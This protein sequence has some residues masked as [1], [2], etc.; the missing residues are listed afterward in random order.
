MNTDNHDPDR[1]REDGRRHSGGDGADLPALR[2]DFLPARGLDGAEGELGWTDD[3]GVDWE[4]LLYALRR[5]KWWIVAATVLGV[6]VGVFLA[7]QV[8]PVYETRATLWLEQGDDRR[9][10]IQAENVFQGQG[11]SDLFQSFAVLEPVVESRNLHVTTPEGDPVSSPLF[12]GFEQSE[13]LVPGLYQLR[14]DASGRLE[15]SREGEGV[16]DVALP[17]DSLGEGVGFRWVPDAG[18]LGSG[19]ALRFRVTPPPQAALDLRSKLTVLYNPQAGSLITT[20]LEGHDPK[21]TATIH[22]AVVSSFLEVAADLKS[23]KLREVV[24]ILERQT[25]IAE[26]RLRESE[27]RLENF[28]V[29]T[30]TLPTEPRA[31]PIPGAEMTRDPVREAYFE[32]RLE[33]QDLERQVERIDQVLAQVARGDTLDVVGLQLIPALGQSASL[34]RALSELVEKEADRRALLHTY[35][36]QFPDVRR[37]NQEIRTL[38]ERTIPSLLRNVRSQLEQEMASLEGQAEAQASELREIPTRTIEEARLRRDQQM[39]EQLHNN[40]LVRLKEAELAASTSLPDL[41]V[42]DRAVPPGSPTSNDGPRFFLMASMAGLGLGVAGALLFDRLDRRVQSPEDVTRGMRLP[43]LGVVPRIE[44]T[45]GNPSEARDVIESFR[46]IR[47][48]LTRTPPRQ[49]GVVLVTS[50]A[51]RDGKSLVSANLAISFAFGGARTVLVDCDTR[52]GNDHSLF[53]LPSSPGLTE[54]LEQGFPVSDAIRATEVEGLSFLARGKRRGFDLELLDSPRMKGLLEEL[55][56]AFDVVVLDSPPLVAGSDALLLG[57]R[58]DKV[59]MVIRA[60]DTNSELARNKVERVVEFGL[61]VVG[62]VLNSVSETAPY[63]HY[64]AGYR[65]YADE[66]ELPA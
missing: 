39:A 61:P 32:R 50:P 31:T 53:E 17:G 64:Y 21:Q 45:E 35:T 7:R 41:Q 42:V 18:R 40:L 26:E 55:R 25:E 5:R 24:D 30:I 66:V 57:E 46:S 65:Y 29:N 11:W 47:I 1:G 56:S 63:Y 6:A 20:R 28:R 10:P 9:G 51:P 19:Q 38:R 36:E 16:V 14:R 37:L 4:R 22:N 12:A 59:V 33:Q 52:R 58:A 60:G 62:A 34:Q 13:D 3:E 23:Q 8:Q 27:F 44:A 48:Q 54:C 43:I 15:L 49:N 2:A